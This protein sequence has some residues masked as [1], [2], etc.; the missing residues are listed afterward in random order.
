M[1]WKHGWLEV[2]LHTFLTLA[3]DE[4]ECSALC[5]SYFNPIKEPTPT[6][7]THN[8]LVWGVGT[9][10]CLDAVRSDIQISLAPVGNWFPVSLS[11]HSSHY[12]QGYPISLFPVASVENIILECSFVSR[13]SLNRAWTQDCDS[14][15]EWDIGKTIYYN[16]ECM[17]LCPY[18][19]QVCG[20]I[21]T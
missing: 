6:P 5:C 12:Q 10:S 13:P 15:V 14:S 2:Q 1:P 19:S 9:R 11:S 7:P 21:I 20:S 4:G 17:L 16:R 18:A 3:L 8:Y